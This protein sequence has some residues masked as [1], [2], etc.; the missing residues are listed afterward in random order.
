[1]EY[2]SYIYGKNHWLLESDL[3]VI[4]EKYWAEFPDH[5]ESLKDYGAFI[6]SMAYEV[7]DLVDQRARPTLIMHDLDGQRID[8]ARISPAHQDLLKRLALINRPPYEG[9]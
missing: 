7:G 9:G 1:M 5:Q 6:G 8:R 4:L 2:Q 3:K